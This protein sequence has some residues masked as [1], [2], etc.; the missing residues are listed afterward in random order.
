[1]EPQP[2]DRYLLMPLNGLR[3]AIDGLGRAAVARSHSLHR[4]SGGL[5][6]DLQPGQ[7]WLNGEQTSQLLRYRGPGS[8]AARRQRLELLLSPLAQRLADPSVVPSLPPLLLKLGPSMETN[9]SQG[10]LLS[11]LAAALQEPQRMRLS[12]LPLQQNGPHARLEPSM[13]SLVLQNW[14]QATPC[15][16]RQSHHGERQRCGQHWRG[17][18]SF[19]AGG[20]TSPGGAAAVGKPDSHHLDPLQRQP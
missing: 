5:Q 20:T 4:H 12:R 3:Q 15:S 1:M 18:G 6:I 19:A 9:L 8:E 17:P 16:Q 13:A 10:E 14:Q 2:P 7:Q 11:L